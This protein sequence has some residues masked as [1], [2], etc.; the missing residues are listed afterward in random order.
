[1][2]DSPDLAFIKGVGLL[3]GCIATAVLAGCI[4]Y[5]AVGI[6][7]N[8]YQDYLMAKEDNKA[9]TDRAAMLEALV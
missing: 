1:M 7:C 8:F 2:S 6:M 3:L 5:C 9:N 4:L